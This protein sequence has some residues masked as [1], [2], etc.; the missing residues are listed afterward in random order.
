MTTKKSPILVVL[1]AAAVVALGTG[2]GRPV[3]ADHHNNHRSQEV[4][5]SAISETPRLLDLRW[6]KPG[7]EIET[8]NT[9]GGTP[10]HGLTRNNTEVGE[11]FQAIAPTSANCAMG[12]GFHFTRTTGTPYEVSTAS[13]GL[14]HHCEI[15]LSSFKMKIQANVSGHSDSIDG[16]IEPVVGA[17]IQFTF[18]PATPR[19]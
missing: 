12:A 3:F 5:N 2:A 9:S 8:F 18:P 17:R 11:G 13:V 1:K 6:E 19:R 16:S 7:M 4:V 15:E 14:F 10:V